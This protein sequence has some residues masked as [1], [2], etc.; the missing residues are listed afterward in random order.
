MATVSRR[1]EYDDEG[2][3]LLILVPAGNILR[4]KKPPSFAIRMRDL[5]MYSEDHNPLFV[6]HI[7]RVCATLVVLFDI[8]PITMQ[9]L[10]S[11]A[12]VIEEGIDDMVSMPPQPLTTEKKIIGEIEGSVDGKRFSADLTQED[13]ANKYEDVEGVDIQTHPSSLN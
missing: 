9:K 4:I 12:S 11:I 13:I 2:Q 10:V 6:E 7:K 1:I 3:P 5:W 8:E